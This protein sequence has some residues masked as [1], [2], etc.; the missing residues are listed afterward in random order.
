MHVTK[1]KR[2]QISQ[3][4]YVVYQKP[5]IGV[6]REY[7]LYWHNTKT[8]AIIQIFALCS[9]MYAICGHAYST[10]K[11]SKLILV[12]PGMKSY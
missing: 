9:I 12:L 8:L 7:V 11:V 10:H 2:P 5:E 3:F 6:A 4:K 1:V